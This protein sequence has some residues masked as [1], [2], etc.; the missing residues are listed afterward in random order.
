MKI[1][2]VGLGKVGELLTETL[3]A[4]NHDL[5]V[6]DLDR[7]KIN[8]IVNRYDVNG[9]CG[10]GATSDI[11]EQCNIQQTDMII[12][13]TSEDELN[14]LVG[15]VG[16]KLGA[17]HAIAR[18]RNP[19]Y[20]KYGS[21]FVEQFGFSMV[22]NPEAETANEILRLI[23]FPNA[24]SIETFAKG[25]IELVGIKMTDKTILNDHALH[26][27]KKVSR[28]NILICAVRRD[29]EIIIPSGNFIIKENDELYITGAHYDITCFCLDIGLIRKR[30]KNVMIVGGSRIGYYLAALLLKQDIRV[31]IIEKNEDR[32]NELAERL[33][34]ATIIF[35]D[36]S[37][38]ELL[39]EEGIE[40][41]DA[42]VCLTGMD[43]E[44][45][46]LSL[47]AKQ[48]NVKK[49]IAKVNSSVMSNMINRLPIDS[50][51]SPK[52][53]IANQIIGYVRA[54][55]NDDES[56]A[57]Q[58][59]YRL[60]D[61]QVEALEFIVSAKADYLGI[62]LQNLAIKKGVLVAAILRNGALIV[63]KGITTIEQGDHV[64]IVAKNSKI[65]RLSNIFEG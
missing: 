36:A 65:E 44:N 41:T 40:T 7:N 2:V 37:D 6:I 18:V 62:P 49:A 24:S 35:G 20:S 8:D 42:L 13:V 5:I 33:S 38:E 17:K 46:V 27:L 11:L 52:Q 30:I 28:A 3:A 64:M 60:V 45:I 25:K 57:V 51:I 22:A 43:E 26:Q 4:E 56:V 59:M 58:T 23:T 55:S 12:S 39:I 21:F 63:P 9:I 31:K 48:L 50:I 34:K 1:I 14:I 54:K 16:K 15:M 53:I 19:D 32:C 47:L 10:N 61:N 29:N